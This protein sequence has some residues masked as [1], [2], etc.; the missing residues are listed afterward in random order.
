MSRIEL[1]HCL[2]AK[3]LQRY[4][5]RLD[6]EYAAAIEELSSDEGAVLARAALAALSSREERTAKG[7]ESELLRVACLVPDA[8]RDLHTELFARGIFYPGT[9]YLGARAEARDKL[10]ARV[11][12]RWW[13]FESGRNGFTIDHLL[14]C[15]A[16]IGDDVICSLFD[17][18]RRRGTSFTGLFVPPWHYANEAGWELDETGRRRDLISKAAYALVPTGEVGLAGRALD[19]VTAHDS[20]CGWCSRE[21]TTLFDCDLRDARVASIVRMPGERLRIAM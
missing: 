10:I 1:V 3:L 21:L 20:A 13:R 9:L 11:E 19:V 12:R 6:E 15:L 4:D 8:L 18:W 5:R 7:G 2:R 17:G 14:Q 16:W